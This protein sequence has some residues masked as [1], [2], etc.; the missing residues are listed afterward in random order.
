V[1]KEAL[2]S[3]VS[4]TCCFKRHN[5]ASLAGVEIAGIYREERLSHLCNHAQAAGLQVSF[6]CFTSLTLLPLAQAASL[7]VSFP[8]FTSLTLL[9]WPRQLAC[10]SAFPALLRFPPFLCAP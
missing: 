9:P 4:I 6:P 1:Y 10:R 8:C 3:S 5:S 7:Q 2:L